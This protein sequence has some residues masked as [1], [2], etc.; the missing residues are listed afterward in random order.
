MLWL[1]GLPAPGKVSRSRLKP[2]LGI[3][4]SHVPE[5]QLVLGQ[6]TTFKGSESSL[7]SP[8]PSPPPALLP[9]SSFQQSQAWPIPQG[10]AGTKHGC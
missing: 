1:S 2:H 8:Q 10:R 3:H 7:A 4:R 9:V 5:S 6:E